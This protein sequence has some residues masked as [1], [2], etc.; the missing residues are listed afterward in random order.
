[1]W[2][3]HQDSGEHM[4]N[5]RYMLAG[6]VTV[7]AIIIIITIVSLFESVNLVSDAAKRE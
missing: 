5:T 4:V 3:D 6:I 2:S 7:V 1:M